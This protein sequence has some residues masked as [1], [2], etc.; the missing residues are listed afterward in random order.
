MARTSR[1]I[2][3]MPITIFDSDPFGSDTI[4]GHRARP[5]ISGWRAG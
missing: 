3:A 1:D 2:L 5:I 4:R